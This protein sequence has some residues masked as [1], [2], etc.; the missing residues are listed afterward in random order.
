MNPIIIVDIYHPGHLKSIS[1]V[2]V[3][4]LLILCPKLFYCNI[5]KYKLRNKSG[6]LYVRALKEMA[7]VL[8]NDQC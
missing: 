6:C 2:T 7:G 3:S 4:E 5:D 1:D 8:S